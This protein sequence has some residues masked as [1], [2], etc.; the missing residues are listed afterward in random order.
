MATAQP[1]VPFKTYALVYIALLFLV[2]LTTGV[3]FIDLGPLNTVV[4]LAIAVAKMMLVLIFFMHLAHST[5][6]TRV[7]VV[8]AFFWLAIMMVLTL[9]DYGSR[10]WIT[11]PPAWS[12]SAP[13]THP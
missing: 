9:S 7:T 10:R 6:L 2:A 5:N 13:A 3:A 12:S 11:D 4:A 8:A 1:V